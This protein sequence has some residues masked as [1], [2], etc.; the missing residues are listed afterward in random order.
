M[1][2]NPIGT[3]LNHADEE[4][5]QILTLWKDS[6]SEIKFYN[7]ILDSKLDNRYTH[8]IVV[9]DSFNFQFS[10]KQEEWNLRFT[11]NIGV[12]VVEF[13][14]SEDNSLYVK[15]MF[16]ENGS[17]VYEILPYTSFDSLKAT[18]PHPEMK[19]LR[20]NVL[21]KILPGIDGKSI[22]DIGCGVGSI[23]LDIAQRN[24]ESRVYGIEILDSLIN[25]CKMNAQVQDVPNADFKTGDIYELPFDNESMDTVTCFFML[26]HI[27]DIPSGLQE[28]K[29]VLNKGGN[30]IAVD[31]LGHH[32][33]PK[34]TETD[35]KNYFEQAGFSVD[36]KKIDNALVSYATLT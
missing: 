17:N 32:H 27:D 9:H 4:S 8:Y 35:W 20:M 16:A 31:P 24:P 33:G 34:I 5:L 29:R 2:F 19:E 13:L 30:L 28:I 14:K 7:N 15:G 3:V 1:S 25:Q 12:S 11:G 26:H 23:T 6:I 22:L 10:E 21:G 36:T 18:Y